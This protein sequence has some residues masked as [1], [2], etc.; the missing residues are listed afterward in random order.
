MKEIRVHGRG[1]Q[2]GMA[3]ARMLA[4]AF[5]H[6]GKWATSFPEFGFERRGAPVRAFVRVDDKPIREKMKVYNPDCLLVIDP[7]LIGSKTTFEGFKPGG[8][9]VLN[10]H[11]AGSYPEMNLSVVGYVNATKI[12]LE[13][14]GITAT[15]TCMLGAFARATEWIGLNSILSSLSEYFSG[16]LLKKNIRC[17]E[18]GFNETTILRY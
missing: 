10:G 17:V 11:E 6:E 4:A 12:G 5:V 8:I 14:I 7:V 3:G 13:E 1:G 9:L 2:G 16:D 15:N 18:R